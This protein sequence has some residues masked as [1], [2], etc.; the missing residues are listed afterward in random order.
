MKS[1]DNILEIRVHE[2]VCISDAYKQ[3]KRRFFAS[4][5]PKFFIKEGF[6]YSRA[7]AM[8]VNLFSLPPTFSSV[9]D[10]IILKTATKRLFY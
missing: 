2:T 1:S 3:K 5:K 4:I 7:I 9:E 6:D 10:R 8:T